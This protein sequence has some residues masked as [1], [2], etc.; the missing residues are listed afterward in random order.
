MKVKSICLLLLKILLF[1]Y[2]SN[3][4]YF[5]ID[6]LNLNKTYEAFK[7]EPTSYHNQLAF[8]DAFPKNFRDFL[9]VYQFQKGQDYDLTMY[10]KG[11]DHIISGL[12][13]LDLIPDTTFCDRIIWLSLGG[14]WEADAPSY[15]QRFV[16]RMVAEKRD[17]MFERLCKLHVSQQVS[18]WFFYFHSRFEETEE[19]NNLLKDMSVKYPEVIESMKLAYP[20][21]N[22]KVWY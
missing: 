7:N 14:F 20:A 18:F 17:V 5:P 21:S 9:M 12:Y 3:G 19:Y 6:T 22:G 11:V 16:H 2:L 4:Q 1:C 8:F 13:K 10:Y 15:L